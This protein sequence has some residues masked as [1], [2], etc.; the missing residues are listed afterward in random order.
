M[1][2]SQ[3]DQKPNYNKFKEI[4]KNHWDTVPMVQ[5]NQ[6]AATRSGSVSFI[7]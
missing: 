5:E 7:F 3:N 6:T 1:P 4:L 2:F